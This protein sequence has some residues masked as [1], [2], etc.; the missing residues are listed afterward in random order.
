MIH[1]TVWMHFGV[2]GVN[3]FTCDEFCIT[4]NC[5]M[6]D[7]VVYS[8]PQGT[9]PHIPP[10]DR[11]CQSLTLDT[12]RLRPQ[13][14]CRQANHLPTLLATMVWLHY[15]GTPLIQTPIGTEE[16]V[17]ISEVSLFQGFYCSYVLHKIF[18]TSAFIIIPPNS[19]V[20]RA[21]ASEFASPS[22]LSSSAS[23]HPVHRHGSRRR[24]R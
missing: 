16:T 7:A 2:K 5:D 24:C 13:C 18:P 22:S 10:G 9:P 8:T 17:F 1:K 15:S 14:P 19:S 11:Q 20:S 23:L 3:D 21:T 4:P 6:S 12:S